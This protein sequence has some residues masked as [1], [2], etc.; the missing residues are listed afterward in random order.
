MED[1]SRIYYCPR[2]VMRSFYLGPAV[3]QSVCWGL[4]SE[5]L[6]RFVIAEGE[7]RLQSAGRCVYMVD[8][9][10]SNQMSTEFRDQMTAFFR[11]N[12][13]RVF[14]NMLIKSR[15]LEMA[16]N[17]ANLV[18]G[19]NAAHAYSNLGDWLAVGRREVPDFRK[20][21]LDLPDEIRRLA[22]M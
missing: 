15:L 20:R 5:A 10:M 4:Q 18:I 9:T 12:K 21:E 1:G 17:V 22:R 2:G 13:G 11:K 7:Q 3:I 8:A 14:V 6:A 19:M 16:L